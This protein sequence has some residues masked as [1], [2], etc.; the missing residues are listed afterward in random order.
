MQVAA[1]GPLILLD[2]FLPLLALLEQH[3]HRLVLGSFILSGA[4]LISYATY[5]VIFRF[6]LRKSVS[7]A[8]PSILLRFRRPAFWLFLIAAT[9]LAVPAF[10]I[11]SHFLGILEHIL[12]IVFILCFSWLL[13]AFIYM[14][15][16][17]LMRRYDVTAA[18]NLRARQVETQLS[19]LRRLA[20]GFVGLL[21]TGVILYTFNHTRVWQYGAGLL[22]S[23]GLASLALAAAAK[24]TVSNLLAGIQIAFTEPIR[25]DDVVIVEGQWGRIEEITTAYVVV[26]I[27]NLQRLIVPLS[28]FI[29]HPFQNW[30]RTSANLMGTF[31]LYA[32]YT[33]PIEPLREELTRIL[34]S[35][36]LWDGKVNVLQ[37]T[38]FTPQA[39]QIRALM[40]ASDSSKLWDL[41]CLVREK[42]IEFLQKNYPDCLPKQRVNELQNAPWQQIDENFHPSPPQTS[43]GNL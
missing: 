11:S 10:G 35:T 29:D 32:D 39:M 6:V 33:C 37:V 21:A 27:W 24:S 19:V 5:S 7:Q 42:M 34:K 2:S 25:I 16:D 26:C 18:D 41:R 13:I 30:T 38:E 31:F 17:L 8:H 22:A 43:K 28:Y 1:N 36:P 23:A 40:S 12:H 20:I 9:M 4:L 14:S 3:A 15:Q